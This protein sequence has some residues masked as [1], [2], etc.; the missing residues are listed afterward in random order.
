MIEAASRP[1]P[2]VAHWEGPALPWD[3]KSPVAEPPALAIA[4]EE[5]ESMPWN[6]VH[7]QL[8]PAGRQTRPGGSR[9]TM[10]PQHSED[11]E[12][13]RRIRAA[14]D[15]GLPWPR[16]GMPADGMAISDPR[17][18][19]S[20]ERVQAVRDDLERVG[21]PSFGAVKPEGGS[22]WLKKLHEFGSP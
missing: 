2:E 12:A 20:Q 14:P 7:T 11:A 13:V 19:R 16:P 1:E 10:A 22:A 8:M 15:W 18:W 5:F 21:A 3:P 6:V 4:E 17:I 9:P